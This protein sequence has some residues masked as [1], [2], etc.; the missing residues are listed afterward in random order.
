MTAD[1]EVLTPTDNASKPIISIVWFKRDLRLSDHQPLK[2]AEESPHPVLL[3]FIFEPMLLNDPHFSERHW[4]F[5]TESLAQ[6]NRQLKGRVVVAHDEALSVF[7]QLHAQFDIHQV[8]SHEEVGLDNTFQRDKQLAAWFNERHIPWR[9]EALGGVVRGISNRTDWSKHWTRVMKA[10]VISN[11]PNEL[12]LV[13]A[14]FDTSKLPSSW[15]TPDPQMQHGGEYTSS[16][17]LFDFFEKRGKLYSVHISKPA[18]SRVSCSRLSPYLAWGNISLRQAYQVLL[19]HWQLPGWRRALVALSS[20]YHWHCHFMQKFESECSMEFESI[21]AGYRDFPCK[22]Q[23]ESQAGLIAWEQGKT[24][25][26]MVDACM[27]CLNATGYVNFRMRA[28][29]VSFLC[30]H[31]QIDWRLGVH[32][33]ARVFLDFEP[34]IHYPQFQMQAGVT[35]INTIR[36]YNPIKQAMEHDAEGVFIRQWCPEL[37]DLPNELIVR[38]HEMTPMEQV[39]YG[40]TIGE[41]YP[42]P[43]VDVTVT[44]KQASDL[45]WTWRDRPQVRSE[46]MRIVRRHVK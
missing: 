44:Y 14:V 33:L 9:E 43:I 1:N 23:A 24:G 31:L 37:A 26:P 20:R 3:L 21:N 25:Y 42:A 28:M 35:G 8:C 11:F 4:R 19:G 10:P 18:L 7:E 15:K 39:M 27:R 6:M 30:H 46:A 41:N 13:K 12:N 5:V 29:L 45:L 34:G 17:V 16:D 22:S 38:P 2:W 36:I 32:H 40:I